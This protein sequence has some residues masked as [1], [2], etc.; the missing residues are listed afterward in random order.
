MIRVILIRIFN[1]FAGAKNSREGDGCGAS[2]NHSSVQPEESQ[3]D[4]T[5]LL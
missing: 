1:I 5:L 4:A 2:K 3:S